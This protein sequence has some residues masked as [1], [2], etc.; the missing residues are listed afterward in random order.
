MQLDE[1]YEK[2]TVAGKLEGPKCAHFIWIGEE[3]DV[4]ALEQRRVGGRWRRGRWLQGGRT[5]GGGGA[6]AD[7]AASASSWRTEG[8]SWRP[9]EAAVGLNEL[10]R[11]SKVVGLGG[12]AG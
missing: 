1:T 9:A 4:E 7:P 8:A 12:G 10:V 3:D 2:S 5:E 11:L 6:G